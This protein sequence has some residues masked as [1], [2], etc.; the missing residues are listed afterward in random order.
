MAYYAQISDPRF[1]G[2]YMSLFN[3]VSN[4]GHQLYMSP[5]LKTIDIASV[6]QCFKE[7]MIMENCG[8]RELYSQCAALGG[9]CVT[10][11]D[12]YLRWICVR[13]RYY[14]LTWPCFIYGVVWAVLMKWQ[15][16]FLMTVDNEKWKVV[17]TV[18]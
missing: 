18:F 5:I 7:E 17:W 2:T 16:R 14:L 4:L 8:T 1:G 12:G 15:F 3:T 9:T 6:K 13:R 10:K 11:Q